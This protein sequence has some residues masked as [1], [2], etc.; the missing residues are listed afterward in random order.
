L[1]EWKNSTTKSIELLTRTLATVFT[2]GALPSAGVEGGMVFFLLMHLQVREQISA[3]SLTVIKCLRVKYSKDVRL[4]LLCHRCVNPRETVNEDLS[5]RVEFIAFRWLDFL[6]RF[7]VRFA[8]LHKLHPSGQ[9]SKIVIINWSIAFKTFAHI[10]RIV[11][12]TIATTYLFL[13]CSCEHLTRLFMFL[14]PALWED[15]SG[16][17]IRACAWVARAFE[18]LLMR[19]DFVNLRHDTAGQLVP[20][21]ELFSFVT[22]CLTCKYGWGTVWVVSMWRELGMSLVGNELLR[23]VA[24]LEHG[25]VDHWALLRCEL[26]ELLSQRNST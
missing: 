24:V 9:I 8:F 3:T 10:L 5:R 6:N 18:H 14:N 4:L 26:V 21:L 19:W 16:W 11:W 23:H 1:E 15:W 13:H 7:L 22:N 12:N 20:L 2:V 17:P 25:L